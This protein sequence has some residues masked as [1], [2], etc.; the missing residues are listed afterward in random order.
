MALDDGKIS[1]GTYAL[2][3]RAHYKF[4]NAQ[5]REFF[6]SLQVLGELVG[7]LSARTA[8]RMMSEAWRTGLILKAHRSLQLPDGTRRG[9]SNLWRSAIPDEYTD[10]IKAEKKATGT[11]TEAAHQPPSRPH[12]TD[13]QLR[14]NR[15][16]A[17]AQ[18][19]PTAA[20]VETPEDEL[21]E[22]ESASAQDLEAVLGGL[23][24]GAA[25][26]RT[27]PRW[28]GAVKLALRQRAARTSTGPP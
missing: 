18:A 20:D 7:G 17:L 6:P 21:V 23:P 27:K 8:Q 2:L 1:R 19:T 3:L 13:E 16:A 5:G 10:R 14:A 9:T 22:I 26:Y 11:G 28:R 12:P 4:S 24:S 15:E 25:D